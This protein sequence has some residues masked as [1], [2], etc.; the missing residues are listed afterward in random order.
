M[1]SS[2]KFDE[3]DPLAVGRQI[4]IGNIKFAEPHQFTLHAALLAGN[5]IGRIHLEVE[6]AV[7]LLNMFY[8]IYGKMK[9]IVG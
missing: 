3:C 6:P 5:E 4:A 8:A 7:H 1:S 9:N 2:A